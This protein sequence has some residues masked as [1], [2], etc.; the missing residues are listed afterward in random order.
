MKYTLQNPMNNDIL[1]NIKY[2]SNKSILKQKYII[3]HN[4]ER[5]F[6]SE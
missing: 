6:L 3:Y 4:E 5:V 1:E 2:I